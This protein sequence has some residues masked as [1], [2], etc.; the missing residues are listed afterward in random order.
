MLMTPIVFYMSIEARNYG[1]SK[2]AFDKALITIGL[3]LFLINF[4]TLYG[5]PAIFS[6]KISL[7]LF[8]INSDHQAQEKNTPFHRVLVYRAIGL[9]T[10]LYSRNFHVQS[11]YAGLLLQQLGLDPRSS[12]RSQLRAFQQQSKGSDHRVRHLQYL[13]HDLHTFIARC[14]SLP[15]ISRKD[16][17]A[18]PSS[19]EPDF[20]CAQRQSLHDRGLL[21]VELHVPANSDLD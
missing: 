4:I 2:I 20:G 3:L 13:H 12:R 15:R 9:P 5:K 16:H 8:P 7:L 11:G 17:Q 21:S 6:L 10:H 19:S 1:L 18:P 14:N